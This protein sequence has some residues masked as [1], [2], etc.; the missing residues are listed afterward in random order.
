[1]KKKTSQKRV[2]GFRCI[3]GCSVYMTLRYLHKPV[4]FANSTVTPFYIDDDR[5][6]ILNRLLVKTTKGQC[7]A[8]RI[9]WCIEV[10]LLYNTL[11]V[12]ENFVLQC[13]SLKIDF[14]E[15]HAKQNSLTYTTSCLSDFHAKLVPQE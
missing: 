7:H 10:V 4:K 2:V 14:E 5:V 3:F 8:F 1:M 11:E 15:L 6:C 12:T 13:S 9:Y